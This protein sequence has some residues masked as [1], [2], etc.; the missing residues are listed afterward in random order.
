AECADA[1]FKPFRERQNPPFEGFAGTVLNQLG[2]QP[3]PAG[4][5]I[6]DVPD[7]TVIRAYVGKKECGRATTK[8]L[9]TPYSPVGNLFGLIV[10]PGSVSERMRQRRDA[11]GLLRGQQAGRS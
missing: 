6:D 7:G 1:L 4:S 2:G 10:P 8:A 3:R 11:G 9:S 5:P